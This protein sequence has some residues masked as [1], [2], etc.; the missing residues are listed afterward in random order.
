MT[1]WRRYEAFCDTDFCAGSL[2][3][4]FQTH[5]SERVC[6]SAVLT[7]SPAQATEAKHKAE[8][9]RK[10]GQTGSSFSALANTPG[11]VTDMYPRS[12]A[13][14]GFLICLVLFC[15]YMQLS[16]AVDL[17]FIW[18]NGHEHY[19]GAAASHQAGNMAVPSVTQAIEAVFED[20]TTQFQPLLLTQSALRLAPSSILRL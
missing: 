19:V 9:V 6:L 1:C 15:A 7:D 2:A 17:D 10:S 12:V 3:A 20:L 13:Y 16:P 5:E 14:K 11:H 8:R 18:I 4:Y